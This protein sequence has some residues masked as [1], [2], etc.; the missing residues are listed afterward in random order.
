MGLHSSRPFLPKALTYGKKRR[1]YTFPAARIDIRSVVSVPNKQS[2]FL[3]LPP[4]GLVHL[5]P[6]ASVNAAE[7]WF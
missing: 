3:S 6:K 4:L 2:F 7:M 1:R 5:N